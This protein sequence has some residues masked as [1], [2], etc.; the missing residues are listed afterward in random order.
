LQRAIREQEQLTGMSEALTGVDGSAEEP[1]PGDEAQP[2]ADQKLENGASAEALAEAD[3]PQLQWQQSR[4]TDWSRML[5]LKAQSELP[6][7]EAQLQAAKARP[8]KTGPT[9]PA[10]DD[11]STAPDDSATDPSAQLEG[12]KKSLQNGIEL[13]PK[14]EQHSSSAAVRLGA[15]DLAGAL[16]DQQQAGKLL[17]EIAEPLAQEN[18]Q[19]DNQQAGDRN[20]EK[21]DQNSQ[22]QPQPDPRSQQQ[23]GQSAQERAQST[24]RRARQRERQHRDLQQQLQQMIGGR[25]RVD[26]DW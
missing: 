17:R 25:V 9:Q 11:D 2:A 12:L 10:D 4:V 5:G 23:P 8:P 22:P 1:G 16:P 14:V 24:L 19:P 15:T 21:Q 18:Q 13:G 3:F 20:D 26:R 7:V 6:G